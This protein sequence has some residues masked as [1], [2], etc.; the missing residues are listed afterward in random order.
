MKLYQSKHIRR[1]AA[2]IAAAGVSL[3]FAVNG[4]ALAHGP[5][6]V[7]DYTLIIGFHNEPVLQG[8]PNSLDLFVTNTKTGEKINGLEKTLKAEIIFGS[9][10]RE[11]ELAPQEDQDGAYGAAILPTRTGDYTWHIFGDING[12]RVDVK[13]TSS[14]TTFESITPKSDIS[15]PDS[16]PALTDVQADAAAAAQSAQTAM[17]LG[18]VGAVLGIVGTILGFMGWRAGQAKH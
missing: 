13:M 3:L 2:G 16:E 15:F 6:Q 18:I 11:V 4:A 8:E 17:I 9:H 5:V 12:T 14:P 10:T 7:G 1:I